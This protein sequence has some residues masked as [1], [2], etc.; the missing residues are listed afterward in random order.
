MISFAGLRAK[1]LVLDHKHLPLFCG[2][3]GPLFPKRP[4]I[5]SLLPHCPSPRRPEF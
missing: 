3:Q 4:Q 1:L 2:L 5:L